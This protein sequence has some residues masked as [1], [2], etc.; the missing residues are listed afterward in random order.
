MQY[1][2]LRLCTLLSACVVIANC[3]DL[4]NEPLFPAADGVIVSPVRLVSTDSL[5]W[6]LSDEIPGFGGNVLR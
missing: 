6:A 3:S 4:S 1:F 2:A 5:F